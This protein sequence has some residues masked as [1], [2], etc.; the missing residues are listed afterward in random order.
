[1]AKFTNRATIAWGDT[2]RDS[3]VVTGE[4]VEVLSMTKNAVRG[5]YL[6][7]DT[8]TYIISIRN[9]GTTPFTGLTVTD[10]LGAYTVG[11]PALTVVPLTYVDG[12]VQMY[13]NGDLLSPPTVSGTDPLTFTDIAVPASSN[14]LLVYEATVNAFAPADPDGTILNT[15]TVTGGG[16]STAITDTAQITAATEASLTISKSL[17]PETVTENGQITYT[18]VIQNS[19]NT[20]AT[21]ADGVVLRD[22]FDPILDP[23]SV[24]YNGTPVSSPAFYT[25]D[26]TTGEFAT[27]PGVITVP[28]AAFSQDPATGIITTTPGVA[29]V[30][31]TGTI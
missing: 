20:E 22:I 29:V 18:F 6:P 12:S 4:I 9:S 30:R 17:C 24:T 16:L 21:A 8:V 5:T 7:G 13:I 3:N 19:G 25:Y 14:L 10:D 31:I 27:V 15:A 28:A 23:I 11:D 26:P 1:M 2:I